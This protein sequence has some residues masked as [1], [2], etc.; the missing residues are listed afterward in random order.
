MD[1]NLNM[2]MFS[3][4]PII[5]IELNEDQINPFLEIE[6]EENIDGSNDGVDEQNNNNT[7][8]DLIDDPESVVGNEDSQDETED[9]S[10]QDD[11]DNSS[12][13]PNLFNSITALLVEK[14]LLSVDSDIKV[15]DEDAF[16]ELF[17]SEIK[18][19]QDSQ[20][21]DYQKE[22]LAKLEKGIPQTVIEKHDTELAQLNSVTEDALKEDVNLRHRVIYQDYVNRGYSDDKAKRLLQRSIELEEDITDSLDAIVSIKELALK[23]QES[24]QAKLIAEKEA[25]KQQEE[26]RINKIKE[27]IKKS[28]EVI[29]DYKITDNVKNKV[30]KNM[31]EIVSTNP[32]TN[33]PENILMKERRENQNDF[34]F[35]L[36]Y[37]FTITNGFKNFDVLTKSSNSKV[38]NDLER[39]FKSNT[40]IKD[41][42]S[43]AYL[44]DPES[45][46]IDIAGH[47]IV[48]D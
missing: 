28:T 2:D 41:P 43:P 24:E 18:K 21:N 11:S 35:K 13:D 16:V 46:S 30:E 20:F 45:Y 39:A 36:Y 40:R 12:S 38:V 42:G 31:F 37:L 48:V 34:D 19:T 44:Q 25:L 6:D 9:E 3:N 8:E 15:E 22:Y 29:K 47:D 27:T 10:N 1:N 7:D 23:R 32:E 4:E 33:A 26:S 17:K 14:G 5:D